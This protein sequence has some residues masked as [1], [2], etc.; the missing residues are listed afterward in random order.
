M[1]TL[2]KLLENSGWFVHMG[3][4]S[5]QVIELA[6]AAGAEGHC[7]LIVSDP[8]CKPM[9]VRV[10]ATERGDGRVEQRAQKH[11]VTLARQAGMKVCT[12]VTPDLGPATAAGREISL[13][14][15]S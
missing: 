1:R 8:D 13:T 12:T 5:P 11:V 4:A 2:R 15:A 6:F 14:I 7:D 10:Y 9:S 3:R